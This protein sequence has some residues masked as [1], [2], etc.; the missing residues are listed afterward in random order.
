[1]AKAPRRHELSDP[2]QFPLSVQ[3]LSVNSALPHRATHSGASPD[4]SPRGGQSENTSPNL[5]NFVPWTFY[6]V[7]L[8]QLRS[9]RGSWWQTELKSL[10]RS[11]L[12]SR[13]QHNPNWISCFLCPTGPFTEQTHF[14]RYTWDR[15]HFG[16][17]IDAKYTNK[18]N[19]MRHSFQGHD[20]QSMIKLM[21]VIS[22]T[23]QSIWTSKSPSL[24]FLCLFHLWERMMFW[25]S[26]FHVVL[27]IEH[28]Y[29]MSSSGLFCLEP[30]RI[31]SVNRE[32]TVM[33]GHVWI[34]TGIFRLF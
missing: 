12:I 33:D 17:C 3:R 5:P 10:W 23:L 29:F 21:S 30:L 9:P 18:K 6:D 26:G 11:A 16:H 15:A 4:G 7:S 22:E 25:F 32:H 34:F 13:S 19:R 20:M 2:P 1:M 24:C 14:Y 8:K 27:D 31:R 28:P